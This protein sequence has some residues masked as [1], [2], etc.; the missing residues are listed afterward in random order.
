M[1]KIYTNDST[2]T[3]ISLEMVIFRCEYN[4]FLSD[5]KR[6]KSN[7]FIFIYFFS[8]KKKKTQNEHTIQD[9]TTTKNKRR[10]TEP[11]KIN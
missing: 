11:E 9:T 3:F 2:L 4:W 7:L 8:S 1:D 6:F 5:V 10:K